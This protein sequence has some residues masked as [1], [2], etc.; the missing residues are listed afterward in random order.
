MSRAAPVI[1]AGVLLG[2][3]L[4]AR[5]GDTLGGSGGI[6][7]AATLPRELTVCGREW[8]RDALNRTLNL[9]EVRR[10][11]G[12]EPVVID[13]GPFAACPAGACS[14][15]P[16]DAPCS[17]VVFVRVGQDAYIDFSLQG[18]P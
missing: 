14:A 16:Q 6:H 13:P 18:G 1:L 8:S 9:A 15:V 4:L 3:V 5:I 7:E 2:L 10:R 17:T 11:D 12:V